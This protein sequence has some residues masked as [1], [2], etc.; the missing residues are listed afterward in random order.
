MRVKDLFCQTTEERLL[1]R[2]LWVW[3]DLHEVKL[4]ACSKAAGRYVG[5]ATVIVDLKG[6]VSVSKL[7]NSRCRDP[8]TGAI[9]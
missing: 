8:V 2:A 7:T 4:P 6:V 9:V 1:N 5:R 3:E